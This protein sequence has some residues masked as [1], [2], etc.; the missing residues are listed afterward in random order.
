[1][2]LTLSSRCYKQW[3]WL[4]VLIVSLSV[5]DVD[6]VW[7]MPQMISSSMDRYTL[8]PREFMFHYSTGSSA[9]AGC[10]LLDSAFKRYFPLIFTGYRWFR[11]PFTVVVHVETAECEGYPDADSSESC[12]HLLSKYTK[13][14]RV[15]KYPSSVEVKL[16]V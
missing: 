4:M 10:S 6:A 1:M 14:E 8:N 2:T 5:S 13:G 7:P 3:L 11:F 9:Q 16:L 12:N 15:L